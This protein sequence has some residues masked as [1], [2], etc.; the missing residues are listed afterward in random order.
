MKQWHRLISGIWLVHRSFY[1]SGYLSAWFKIDRQWWVEDGKQS[2]TIT[3][4]LWPYQVN[5]VWKSRF[6]KRK[7]LDLRVPRWIRTRG[8][9]LAIRR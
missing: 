6:Y 8:R 4:R 2:N 7:A 3:I 5:I 9:W 1:Y